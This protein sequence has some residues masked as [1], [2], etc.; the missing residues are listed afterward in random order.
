MLIHARN[1]SR[2]ISLGRIVND[3]HD[4]TASETNDV[5]AVRW[6]TKGTPSVTYRDP[7][8]FDE[9]TGTITEGPLAEFPTRERNEEDQ[10]E[11]EQALS[12]SHI[13]RH[14]RM[15]A[16]AAKTSI[17]GSVSADV[18]EVH[19]KTTYEMSSTGKDRELV[20]EDTEYTDE[21]YSSIGSK[22]TENT[23]DAIVSG[24]F[25]SETVYSP[26]QSSTSPRHRGEEYISELG[27]DLFDVIQA[28]GLNREDLERISAKLPN[29]LR[30]FALKLGHKAPTQMHRDV[31][32]FVYKHRQ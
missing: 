10:D 4:D 24:L 8:P 16:M 21:R 3:K 12:E 6:R 5:D 7:E 17:S 2:S 26:T 31:S 9:V 1:K 18:S 15:R 20:S 23:A 32:Y 29:L 28:C 27:E 22:K 13:L 25:A 14:L 11:D 30:A 19:R